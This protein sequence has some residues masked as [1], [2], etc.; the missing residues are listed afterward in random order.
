MKKRY[1]LNGTWT[2]IY[3]KIQIVPTKIDQ[4]QSFFLILKSVINN[5]CRLI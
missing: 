4:F 1:G 5:I 2:D 3:L